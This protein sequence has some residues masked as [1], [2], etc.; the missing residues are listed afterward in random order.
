MSTPDEPGE[1]RPRHAKPEDERRVE[2]ERPSTSYSLWDEPN[3]DA[4]RGA[5]AGSTPPG[6]PEVDYRGLHADLDATDGEPDKQPWSTAAFVLAVVGLLLFPIIFGALGIACG[7][8]GHRRGE[9]LGYWSAVAA[10]TALLAGLAIRV[11]FFDAD[12]IPAQN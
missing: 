6:R 12:L 9:R 8:Y 11:F 10:L 4:P 7:L 2:P 5:R 1:Y 3:A